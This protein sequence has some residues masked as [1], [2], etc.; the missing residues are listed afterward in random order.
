MSWGKPSLYM[1]QRGGPKNEP[2]GTLQSIF[3]LEELR[4]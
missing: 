1:G 2:C 4:T 3:F